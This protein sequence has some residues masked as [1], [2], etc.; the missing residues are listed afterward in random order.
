MGATDPWR[1]KTGVVPVA[2]ESGA[3]VVGGIQ[4]HAPPPAHS[5]DTD[6]G[7]RHTLRG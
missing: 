1:C 5:T 6:T 3:M 7:S 2:P 4:E